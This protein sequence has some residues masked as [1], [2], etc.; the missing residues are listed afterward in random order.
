MTTARNLVGFL[1]ASWERSIDSAGRVDL[2]VGL[3]VT[4]VGRVMNVDFGLL[5]VGVVVVVLLV[6]VLML[7]PAAM[8]AEAGH[9][10]GG[11]PTTVINEPGGIVH[12]HNY[13]SGQAETTAE[14]TTASTPTEGIAAGTKPQ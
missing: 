13:G 11:G 3:I 12:I 6:R 9:K 5:A 1:R 8:W 7:S 4:L 14:T 2:I 10:R